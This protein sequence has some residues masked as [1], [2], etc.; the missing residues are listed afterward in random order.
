MRK[1][2]DEQIRLAHKDSEEDLDRA[3]KNKPYEIA[4]LENAH[5][6]SILG[7]EQLKDLQDRITVDKYN[8]SVND[9]GRARA[10]FETRWNM[11][12]VKHQLDSLD[13]IRKQAIDDQALHSQKILAESDLEYLKKHNGQ[14][15]ATAQDQIKIKGLVKERQME[16]EAQQAIANSYE[17]A[18]ERELREKMRPLHQ[19]H[20]QIMQMN[21]AYDQA[22]QREQKFANAKGALGALEIAQNHLIYNLAHESMTTG[23]DI[24]IPPITFSRG[25]MAAPG[26]PGRQET[27]DLIAKWQSMP[28]GEMMKQHESEEREATRERPAPKPASPSFTGPADQGTPTSK[29]IHALEESN[30]LK[31]Q[32]GVYTRDKTAMEATRDSL[33]TAMARN[34]MKLGPD[35][36]LPLDI[37]KPTS[38]AENP[39]SYTP[40]AQ[41]EQPAP[42]PEER[43]G[44]KLPPM[45]KKDRATSS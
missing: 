28:Y 40:P 32:T 42:V 31:A 18:Q 19:R 21:N 34:D 37:K 9:L 39:Y 2:Q 26:L 11:G 3:V 44:P 17:A 25:D 29:Y 5:A 38:R 33:P 35:D 13:K 27:A 6:Q 24:V 22:L 14:M 15:I 10:M 45:E 1:F 4:T 43:P 16:M 7:R 41:L 8:D 36:P 12:L 30:W 20:A 23:R